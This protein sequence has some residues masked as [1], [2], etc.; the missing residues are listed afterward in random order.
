MIDTKELRQK[1]QFEGE[2]ITRRQTLLLLDEID[3]LRSNPKVNWEKVA[4]AQWKE[5]REN[6]VAV[7]KATRHLM[8]GLHTLGWA[9]MD[10]RPEAPKCISHSNFKYLLYSLQQPVDEAL[11]ACAGIEED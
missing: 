7:L 5:E 9:N 11:K 8:V 3:R 4:H 6:L 10:S 1:V 2:Q